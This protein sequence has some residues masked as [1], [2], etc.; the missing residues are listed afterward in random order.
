M[1]YNIEDSDQAPIP[2]NKSESLWAFFSLFILVLGLTVA[3]YKS[4]LFK[5]PQKKYTSPESW[6]D[7]EGSMSVGTLIR[8]FR[9]KSKDHGEVS[10]ALLKSREE[11]VWSYD[12]LGLAPDT[13][14]STKPLILTLKNW[15]SKF[16]FLQSVQF[17]Q[18]QS[19]FHK[20]AL[21]FK[22]ALIHFFFYY[23]KFFDFFKI[24]VCNYQ[25]QLYTIFLPKKFLL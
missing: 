16:P 7:D 1:D 22:W 21:I 3:I 9:R 8:G 23:W 4:E 18:S 12:R 25:T 11:D 17:N 13:K 5:R 19:L 15:K 20:C 14:N 2:V 6:S 10:Y 24:N